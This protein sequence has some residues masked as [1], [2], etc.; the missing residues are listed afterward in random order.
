MRSGGMTNEEKKENRK[1]V[2]CLFT[3]RG[4]H[5][6]ITTGP[7]VK[8]SGERRNEPGRKGFHVVGSG[9]S[10]TVSFYLPAMQPVALDVLRTGE[11]DLMKMKCGRVQPI[12]EEDGFSSYGSDLHIGDP[13]RR[14]T[15]EDVEEDD[16]LDGPGEEEME[17]W[18]GT[19]IQSVTLKLDTGKDITVT[20]TGP[21]SEFL[22]REGKVIE[23]ILSNSK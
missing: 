23:E 22:Q 3:M 2:W 14:E 21:A 8:E 4:W 7:L 13:R 5:A 9:R 12:E 18:F 10:F 11:F 17:N 20:S 1:A 16:Q 6:I 19:S 15:W